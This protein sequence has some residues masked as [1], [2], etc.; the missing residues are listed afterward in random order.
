MSNPIITT[1]GMLSSHYLEVTFMGVRYSG[2]QASGTAVKR[3]NFEKIT[4]VLLSPAH[5]LSFQIG[6]EIFRIPTK[7]D[8]P[9]HQAAIAALIAGLQRSVA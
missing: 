7:P 3:C 8:D 4:G 5:E 2:A 9:K 1:G 6:K